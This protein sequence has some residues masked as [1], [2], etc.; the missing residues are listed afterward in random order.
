MDF[1]ALYKAEV[2]ELGVSY[3]SARLRST[4]AHIDL[5]EM[6]RCLGKAIHMHIMNANSLQSQDIASLSSSIT[7]LPDFYEDFDRMSRASLASNTLE[8]SLDSVCF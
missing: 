8:Y 3:D 1:E 7:S 2:P 5:E 4:L 6:C